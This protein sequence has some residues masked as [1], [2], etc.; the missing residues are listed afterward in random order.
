MKTISRKA[1]QIAA[2]ALQAALYD[3]NQLMQSTT[4]DRLPL[5]DGMT[6]KLRKTANKM[7]EEAEI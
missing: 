6:R 4:A 7:D 2:N 1:L 5:P 3:L